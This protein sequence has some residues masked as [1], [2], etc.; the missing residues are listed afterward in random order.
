MAT[1]E[2]SLGNTV[3]LNFNNPDG[4]QAAPNRWTEEIEKRTN[5]KV[6]FTHYASW[7][8]EIT[9]KTDAL[10]EV[11]AR[12]GRY[13]LVDLVQIPFVFP[14]STV[15]TKV[16]CQLYAEFPQMR[17]ELSDVKM[18]GFG[19]GGLMAI[20][21]T[22]AWGPIRTMEDLKG[23][24]MRSLLPIDGVVEA[25]GAKP[26]HVSFLEIASALEKGELDATVLGISPSKQF[27]L[28]EKG[29]PYCT[30]VGGMSITMHPIRFCMKW[31]SWNRLPS[32]IQ[33]IIDELG[34]YGGD[35]WYAS[36]MG[37][38]ADGS[39]ADAQKYIMDNGGEIIIPPSE[40]LER[41]VKVIQPLRAAGIKVAEDNGEPGRKFFNRMLELVEEYSE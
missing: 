5:G 38:E 4:A 37:R 21:S 9:E 8:P 19:I 24:R 30:I 26:L 40:E 29:V 41:W 7:D 34:P 18:C 25:L 6:H 31:D 1:P 2:P 3:E 33:E 36:H 22:K 35:C 17:E 15:G 12:G 10:R 32:D 28:A 14:S 20:F 39:A 16:V 27:K 11:V 23:A 13:R